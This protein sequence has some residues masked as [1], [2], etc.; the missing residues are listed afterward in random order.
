VVF[1]ESL[2]DF[3]GLF[4]GLPLAENDLRKT[5]A[6]AAV[7]IE[8]CTSDIIVG[9][10]AQAVERLINRHFAGFYRIEDFFE[11]VGIHKN[12]GREV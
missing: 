10:C 8:L 5:G 11:P 6:N 3:Y 4:T 2:H 12:V 7:Q 1:G 9:Q